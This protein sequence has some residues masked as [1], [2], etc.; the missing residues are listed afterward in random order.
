[1]T[2]TSILDNY[3]FCRGALSYIPNLLK[4][5]C[6]VNLNERGDW[7][8]FSGAESEDCIDR[9]R[10]YHGVNN[11]KSERKSI[12]SSKMTLFLF[13]E[14]QPNQASIEECR[15]ATLSHIFTAL[16]NRRLQQRINVLVTGRRYSFVASHM[17]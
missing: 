1:M 17:Q 6:V 11:L 12:R 7:E 5:Y 10:L 13:T 3:V 16:N 14:I 4:C 15:Q 9:A 2:S 8:S